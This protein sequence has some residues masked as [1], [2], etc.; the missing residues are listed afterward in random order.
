MLVAAVKIHSERQALVAGTKQSKQA[1]KAYGLACWLT[2]QSGLL[3]LFHAC[4]LCFVLTTNI[5]LF[6]IYVKTQ[7]ETK[8]TD[9]TEESDNLVRR[10][11]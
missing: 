9:L 11:Y 3:N 8:R 4:L 2:W 10:S 6:D 5:L 7:S 1:N